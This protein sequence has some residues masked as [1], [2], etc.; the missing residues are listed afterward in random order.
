MEKLLAKKQ[1]YI[2]KRVHISVADYGVEEK[3]E[4]YRQTLIEESENDRAKKIEKIDAY[5]EILDELI[6]EKENEEMQELENEEILKNKE[7]E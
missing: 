4:A 7:E 6:A 3:V 1:A 2:E 5:L